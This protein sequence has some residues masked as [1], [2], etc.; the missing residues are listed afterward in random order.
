MGIVN[1]IFYLI[2]V[3][4][5]F[6]FSGSIANAADLRFD[7]G[8]GYEPSAYDREA[9]QPTAFNGTRQSQFTGSPDHDVKWSFG[10]EAEILFYSCN[11]GRR[12]TLCWF[13]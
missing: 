5:S 11:W 2:F 8:K 7:Q 6:N 12:R 4:A 3:V 10:T 1:R 9:A 13:D